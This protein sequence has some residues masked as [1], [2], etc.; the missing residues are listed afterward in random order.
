MALTAEDALRSTCAPTLLSMY[1]VKAA[2]TTTELIAGWQGGSRHVPY[3]LIEAE[4]QRGEYSIVTQR[5]LPNGMEYL[6]DLMRMS[7]D[8]AS[9]MIAHLIAGD[10]NE[11]PA[12]R[13][14]QFNQWDR[15]KWESS[16]EP[17]GSW[18]PQI[19]YRPDSEA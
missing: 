9:A 7:E 1:P 3:G 15:N 2:P 13:I 10:N 5:V 8:E 4:H 16:E 17:Y 19:V 12:D 18:I 11:L 14:F 6:K